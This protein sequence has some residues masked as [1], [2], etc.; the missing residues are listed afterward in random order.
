MIALR[1]VQVDKMDA[2]SSF[3]AMAQDGAHLA[4]SADSR[5]LDSE[6]NLDLCADGIL[7][8]AQNAHANRTQVRQETW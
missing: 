3:P 1:D 5:F 2:N 7:F 6:M 8:F 4:S